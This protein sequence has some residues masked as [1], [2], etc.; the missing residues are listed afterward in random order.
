MTTPLAAILAARIRDTG[1]MTVAAYMGECLLHPRYGYYTNRTV[2]GAGG[3]FTTAPEISQMFGE[4]IGAFLV[5]AWRHAGRPAPF[6]LAEAGPGR[7][8]LMADVLRVAKLDR[9]FL[10]AAEII[11]VEASPHLAAVQRQTLGEAADRVRWVGRIEEIPALPL[12]LVAN[13]FLDALPVRQFVLHA[14]KWVERVVGLSSDGALVFGLGALHL[15]KGA[16]PERITRDA[17]DGT[18]IEIAPAR[19]AVAATI[20]DHVESHGGL[21]L[22]ID[23]GHTMTSAGDTL[24]AVRGH[25]FADVLAEPGLADITSH[26]DFEAVSRAAHR[27]GAVILPPMTQAEFLL[28]NGILDR[29]G[30]LGHGRSPAEQD[31]IRAAVARLC[32]DGANEMGDLFKVLAIA[33]SHLRRPLSPFD[34]PV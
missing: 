34:D 24:Q 22:L 1:P 6:V 33:G 3:D 15:D 5:E 28:E 11:L 26:V 9:D 32:G 8:T 23:Y 19:E 14:G 17:K 7:G 27:A 18:I 2:F 21:A 30:R 12:I 31:A 16:V 10:T 29:A 13:E 4:I 25:A 20:A